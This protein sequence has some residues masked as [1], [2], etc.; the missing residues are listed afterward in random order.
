[1]DE[2][3]IS[4]FPDLLLKVIESYVNVF[5][6]GQY[7]FATHSPI[8]ASQ[9]DPAERVILEFDENKKVFNRRGETPEGDDP[10]DI[11]IK[12]FG[13]I[14]VLGRKG[15]EALNRYIDLKSLI[16]TEDNRDKLDAYMK[17]LLEVTIKYNFGDKDENN[18]KN[19]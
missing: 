8:V 3:E 2:P 15:V 11:L 1:M 16:L 5:P 19:N 12:D 10:N 4:L 13:L 9:F 6:N 18:N 17:E 14:N 7:F